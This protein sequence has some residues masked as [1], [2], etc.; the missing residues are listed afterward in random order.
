M[1]E[2]LTEQMTELLVEIYQRSVPGGR[3]NEIQDV[4]SHVGLYDRLERLV[5]RYLE[6]DE[7]DR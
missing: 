1:G 7:V 3:E 6:R 5:T 2:S 4:L